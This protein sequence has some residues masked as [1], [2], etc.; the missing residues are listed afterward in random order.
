M[1]TINDVIYYLNK[2]DFTDNVNH[3]DFE[4]LTCVKRLLV[5][6]FEDYNVSKQVVVLSFVDNFSYYTHDW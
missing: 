5:K 2:L 3:T 6:E 4:N 1:E